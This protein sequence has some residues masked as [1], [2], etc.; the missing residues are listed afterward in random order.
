M[1]VIRTKSQDHD[2]VLS[3]AG[4]E[5]AHGGKVSLAGVFSCQLV[6]STQLCAEGDSAVSEKRV[7]FI[8]PGT[9]D[10]EKHTHT[11]THALVQCFASPVND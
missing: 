11:R 9:L 2:L 4:S 3:P 5:V 1:S 7:L 10:G 8:F 6:S